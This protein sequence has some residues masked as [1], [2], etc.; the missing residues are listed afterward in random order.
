MNHN[1]KLEIAK[2]AEQL[3]RAS[4]DT[5]N[6]N[7]SKYARAMV[8]PGQS[9]PLVFPSPAPQRAG[10]ALFPLVFALE[11]GVDVGENFGVIVNPN[12]GAVLVS[13]NAAAPMDTSEI[14]TSWGFGNVGKLTGNGNLW[15][16]TSSSYARS[17][18]STCRIRPMFGKYA[19]PITAMAGPPA[20]TCTVHL[21]KTWGA[22]AARGQVW[23]HDTVLGGW[24]LVMDQG[25]TIG[26]E[27]LAAGASLT[28]IDAFALEVY[29]PTGVNE[30]QGG[31]GF[32]LSLDTFTRSVGCHPAPSE[33][34]M[35]QKVPAWDGLLQQAEDVRV[36]A[37]DALCTYLG[38]S[39]ENSGSVAVA[40]VR[41]DLLPSGNTWYDSIASLPYD[42]YLGRLASQGS[43]PGGAHWHYVPDDL[44][45]FESSST[46][47]LY[48]SGYFG[49]S[50]LK[51]GQ[52]VKF[53]CNVMINFYSQA[54][55][56]QMSITPAFG[57]FAALCSALRTDCPLVSSNDEHMKK[58]AEWVR[59]AG[60]FARAADTRLAVAELA[61]LVSLLAV[62]GGRP[63]IALISGQ[64]DRLARPKPKVSQPSRQEKK[65]KGKRG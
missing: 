52:T 57:S 20:A 43:S 27:Y 28:N 33:Y 22:P 8:A 5:T 42:K 16:P 1:Q 12:T 18:N 36:V 65:K 62:A 31:V 38:S 48:P 26:K 10:A 3:A 9:S 25:L 53:E 56:Y 2:E 39:L 29:V 14:N 17:S 64:V 24:S 34:Q 40:N 47:M 46:E 63:D 13:T 23:F 30:D 51:A 49:I 50:G 61:K 6:R 15:K 54:P 37:M 35:I 11:G 19:Y 60:D 44:K 45:Q 4:A 41:G 59:K 21:T 7:L 55:Q 32:Q 58:F